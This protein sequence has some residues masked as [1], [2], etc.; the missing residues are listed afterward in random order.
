MNE[1]TGLE[2]SGIVLKK[3][4]VMPSWNSRY[5]VAD[6]INLRLKY[7]KER[8]VSLLDKERGELSLTDCTVSLDLQCKED[9]YRF[10]SNYS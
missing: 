7:Y 10:F 3:A 2:K 4:Q 1:N 6:P 5:L 9:E 8:P